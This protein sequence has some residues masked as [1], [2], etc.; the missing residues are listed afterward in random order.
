MIPVKSKEA[1]IFESMTEVNKD[2][3]KGEL[4]AYIIDPYEGYVKEKVLAPCD[5][6]VFFAHNAP[7]THNN[8]VLYK[9]I[10]G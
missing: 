8:T 6:T 7:M 9:M 4:L 1:G 5:G 10:E 2:V 3:K